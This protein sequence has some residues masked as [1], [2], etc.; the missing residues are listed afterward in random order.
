MTWPTF[1][2]FWTI[3]TIFDN[4]WQFL[5]ILDNFGQF[6]Q[7]QWQSQRLRGGIHT[8]E[9]LDVLICH[10][11]I[12][13]LCIIISNAGRS[14]DKKFGFPLLLGLVKFSLEYK[15]G[16]GQK[17][18]EAPIKTGD[19]DWRVSWVKILYFGGQNSTNCSEYGPLDI[20]KNKWYFRVDN[21]LKYIANVTP[22]FVLYVVLCYFSE[23][24]CHFKLYSEYTDSLVQSIH[25]V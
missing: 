15:K 1:W 13:V 5:T 6:W 7:W 14:G 4:F 8:D 18:L 3:L 21:Q 22:I 24:R 23:E 11:V 19:E 20:V 10:I 17:V 9:Q 16:A 25:C 12:W 2:Q